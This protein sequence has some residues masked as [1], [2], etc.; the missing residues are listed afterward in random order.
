VSCIAGRAVQIAS[1]CNAQC[2]R[3]LGW[4]AVTS[5]W[6][7]GKSLPAAAADLGLVWE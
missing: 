5:H 7:V 4:V 1:C 6:L 2:N 3:S